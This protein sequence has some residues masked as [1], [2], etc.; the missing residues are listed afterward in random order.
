MNKK[1]LIIFLSAVILMVAGIIVLS[2]DLMSPYVS[3]ADARTRAGSYVQLIGSLDKSTIADNTGRGFSFTMRDDASGRMRVSYNE[4]RPMN[5]EHAEQAVVLGRFN[6][7]KN[8][9][10]ADKLLVKCPSKYKKEQ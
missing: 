7:E 9:F 3:F 10:E 6:P 1:R 5:F 8:L 4:G 2:K